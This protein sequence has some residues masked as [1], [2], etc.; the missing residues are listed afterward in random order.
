ME[1]GMY[2]TQTEQSACAARN[3]KAAIRFTDVLHA[4]VLDYTG[5][6]F[7]ANA[8]HKCT[9]IWMQAKNG[10]AVKKY[11]R[12]YDEQEEITTVKFKA[13]MFLWTTASR[14]F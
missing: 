1:A 10:R 8:K 12:G 7:K 9:Q 11:W 2:L 4:R 5:I 13:V 6:K 3:Q 14:S